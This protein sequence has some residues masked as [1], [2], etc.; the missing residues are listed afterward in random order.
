MSRSRILVPL[1]A[2]VLAGGATQIPA[3][4]AASKAKTAK[5]AVNNDFFSPSKL[6]VTKGT[7]VTWT[8]H[9]RHNVTVDSGPTTFKSPTKSSGTY[10]RTLRK[11]G[12]YVLY[13]SIHNFQMTVKVIK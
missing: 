8:F 7:K 2:L 13:C 5:V 10:S 12:K 3:A 1:A 6:T 4:T 11:A 9:G